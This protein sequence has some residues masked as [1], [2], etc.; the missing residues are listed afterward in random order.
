MEEEQTLRAR[1]HPA[2]REVASDEVH[3]LMAQDHRAFFGGERRHRLRGHEHDW[4]P[5]AAHLRRVDLA[6]EPHLR[7]A[8]QCYPLRK[9]ACFLAVPDDRALDDGAEDAMGEEKTTCM[10]KDDREP[11]HHQ[12]LW[13][14]DC[15]DWQLRIRATV[16]HPFRGAL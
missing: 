2:E 6:G 15:T 9:L 7:R 5:Q 16:G 12:E 14:R 3:Q 8:R 4:V 1:R 11:K 10:E 13:P